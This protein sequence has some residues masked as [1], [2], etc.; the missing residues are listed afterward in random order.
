M[1]ATECMTHWRHLVEDVCKYASIRSA[2]IR[3]SSNVHKFKCSSRVTYGNFLS[4]GLMRVK[5]LCIFSS[6]F[7]CLSDSVETRQ[8]CICS[9]CG[10]TSDLY[11]CRG[12]FVDSFVMVRLMNLMNLPARQLV[13]TGHA[14]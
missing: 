10:L 14:T 11:S 7:I 5:H 6:S 13:G 12:I 8:L 4:P 2:R 1:S 9:K 3:L